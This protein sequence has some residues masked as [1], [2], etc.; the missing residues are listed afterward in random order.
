MCLML[1]AVSILAAPFMPLLPSVARYQ[2]RLGAVEFGFLVA[3]VGAGA[4]CGAVGLAFLSAKRVHYSILRAGY[5]LFL[6]GIIAL[7][8]ART[9]WVAAPILVAVG[10]G[11]N[12]TFASTN[13]I[14]QLRVPDHL[15][16][17]VMAAFSQ[18]AMGITPVGTLFMGATAKAIGVSHAI[19][20]GAGAAALIGLYLFV[21]VR[22]DTLKLPAD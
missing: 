10:L 12:W 8:F 14:L 22:N 6:G 7:S 21:I 18:L 13:T 16:G 2:L 1:A 15:R 4:G 9:F 17:R 19:L 11:F 5:A 20:L 3:C